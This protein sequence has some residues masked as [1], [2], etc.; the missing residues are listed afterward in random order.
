MLYLSL[1]MPPWEP[2]CLEHKRGQ[3]HYRSEVGER[4]H[5]IQRNQDLTFP[6]ILSISHVFSVHPSVLTARCSCRL[7][8]L[9]FWNMKVPMSVAV[10]G[11]SWLGGLLCSMN[12]SGCDRSY[13]YCWFTGR[14]IEGSDSASEKI[15]WAWRISFWIVTSSQTFIWFQGQIDQRSQKVHLS[16]DSVTQ[17]Q[18]YFKIFYHPHL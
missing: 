15:I 8:L 18:F 13:L 12:S 7:W 17:S 2:L 3:N 6:F 5:W 14:R 10:V 1:T 11:C 16:S 9:L 4:S